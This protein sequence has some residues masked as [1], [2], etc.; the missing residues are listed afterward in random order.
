M[1]VIDSIDAFRRAR[2]ALGGTVAFVPTM[3]FLHDGHLELM[4]EAKRRADHLVVS[5]FV[6]PTQFAPDEDLDAYPRDPRGDRKKCEELGAELLFMPTPDIMYA[7]DHATTV[8]VAGLDEVLCGQSRPTHFQ[9]VCT[10]VSKLFNIVGP[11]VAV[12][13]EKD[14]Q[15]LAILRRMTRDLNF[16][17]EIVGVPTVREQ[18][19]LAISSRNKYL[20]GQQ[21]RDAL[22]L[23]QALARAGQSFQDGERDAERLVALAKERL[24]E[25]VEAEAVDYV[26]CV[27]PHSLD[28]LVGDKR[29]IDAQRGA[30]LA[31]AVQVGK[32]RLIDNLR[33]DR[34]LPDALR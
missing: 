3:G 4:R 32:A 33:L 19:G 6:N 30:V 17:I 23:S 8:D 31:M 14:Y 21:R 7:S 11:D 26:E 28:R 9:G 18:D 13:G 20:D 16:P 34:P 29:H 24:H 10:V 5:I 2:R 22:C 27:D 1:K 15:Q 25:S 12:F